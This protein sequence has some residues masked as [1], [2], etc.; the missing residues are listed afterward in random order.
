MG[1]DTLEWM[2]SASVCPIPS[3]RIEEAEKRPIPGSD[4]RHG[5]KR[6]EPFRRDQSVVDRSD[7]QI[8]HKFR[9]LHRLPFVLHAGSHVALLWKSST[10]LF[11]LV[12]DGI[13]CF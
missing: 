4:Q 12:L 2:L 9:R 1:F 6:D 7:H 8:L 3:W 10:R 11:C 5:G 13:D